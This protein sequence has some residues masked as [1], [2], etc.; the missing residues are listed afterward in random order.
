MSASYPN[1]VRTFTPKQDATMFVLGAHVNDLQ[2]EMVAVQQSLGAIP[3]EWDNGATLVKLYPSVKARLDDAQN[4]VV[5]MQVQI[6]SIIQQLAAIG[7][8]TQRVSNLEATVTN[9]NS[10]VT[11]IS[12]NISSMTQRLSSDE[13]RITALEGNTGSIPSQIQQLQQQMAS[14]QFGAAASILNT[15]QSIA[16][17]TYNWVILNWNSREYDNVGIF[18]GGSSLLC[19]QDGWWQINVMGL[20][21]N[22]RGGGSSTQCLANLGLRINGNEVASASQELQLGIGGF[23]RL[24]VPWAGPWYRGSFVQAAINI[25]PYPGGAPSASARISFTRLHGL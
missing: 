3:F 22:T 8:L 21:A 5:L 15:G 4:T 17:D 16:A 1:S 13:A 19:P 6:A 10:Q 11:A 20:I 24:N 23:F 25:N 18:S 14:L 12:A 9:L 2:D 7:P